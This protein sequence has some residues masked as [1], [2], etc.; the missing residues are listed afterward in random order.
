MLAEMSVA[1]TQ[2]FRH[3]EQFAYLRQQV[4]PY[5]SS[6]PAVRIWSAGCSTGEEAYSLAILLNEMGM[7]KKSRIF[8]TDINS[9]L[10][11]IANSASYPLEEYATGQTNYLQA[12]GLSQFD[13]FIDRNSR[14]FSLK[15]NYKNFRRFIN[16]RSS[17]MEVLMNFSLLSVV[18]C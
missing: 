12:G 14:Y 3:P 7:E 13:H 8:A 6:F 11:D 5:L 18:M 16:I 9:H 1:V 10:L 17:M 2:F 15:E 4:L